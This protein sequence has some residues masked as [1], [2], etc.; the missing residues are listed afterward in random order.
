MVPLWVPFYSFYYS[1]FSSFVVTPVYIAARNCHP[2]LSIR[3]YARLASMSRQTERSLAID[4][5]QQQQQPRGRLPLPPLFHPCSYLSNS[6]HLRQPARLH[7]SFASPF[8]TPPS[9]PLLAYSSI[10]PIAQNK[11]AHGPRARIVRETE[12][13]ISA[14]FDRVRRSF[15]YRAY[16]SDRSGIH[17]LS[18]YLTLFIRRNYRP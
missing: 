9:G 14:Q 6:F 17:D 16:L 15:L 11:A 18:D 1:H 7:P 10:P 8:L 12:G 13:E 2:R 5:P 3:V 4:R